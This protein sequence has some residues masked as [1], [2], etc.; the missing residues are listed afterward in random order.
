MKKTTTLANGKVIKIGDRVCVKFQD[1]K[2]GEGASF[3][4]TVQ[5]FGSISGYNTATVLFEGTLVPVTVKTISIID[6]Y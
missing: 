6:K 2:K 3:P 5:Q 4:A 1:N